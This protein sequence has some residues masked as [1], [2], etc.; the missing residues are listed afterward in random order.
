MKL[1]PTVATSA[2]LL[3]LLSGCGSESSSPSSVVDA[4]AGNSATEPAATLPSTETSLTT[5]ASVAPA[6]NRGP[7]ASASPSPPQSQAP[8]S[9]AAQPKVSQDFLIAPR[10]I[11]P[12]KAGMTL[13]EIKQALGDRIQYQTEEN[14]LVDFSAIAVLKG[15]EVL[16]YLMFYAGDPMGDDDMVPLVWVENPKFQTAEGVGPGTT[17]RQASQA[18]GQPTL[19]FSYDDEM[20][21]YVRFERGPENLLFRCTSP[22]DNPQ[23]E[24][25][26]F[27]GIYDLDSPQGSSFYSTQTYR[28]KAELSAII[29]SL[30]PR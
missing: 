2:L 25:D 22:I 24:A 3:A 15:N 19:S 23:S 11:G 27:A 10:Q 1:T 20:R 14:F 5:T 21:E 17:I 13:G 26:I 9:Q 7:S 18:Y 30:E 6:P 16:F 8:Q 12:L 4:A 28:D 29:V